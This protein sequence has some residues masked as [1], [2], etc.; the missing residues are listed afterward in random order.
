MQLV[1][2]QDDAALALFHL[3]QHGFQP[4]LKLA[5]V[6]C[7]RHQ[8]AHVQAENRLVLQPLGHVAGHDALGK[9]LG[10]GGLAHARLAD[11]HGVVF[12][13][14]GEDAH[15]VADLGVAADDR[16]QLVGPGGLHQVLAVLFQHVV[17]LLRVL[18]GH[19]LV[20]AHLHQR[21]QKF[22]LVQPPGPKELPHL[23]AGGLKQAQHQMLHRDVLV[24]HLARG[25]FRRREGAVGIGGNINFFRV[26][27]AAGHVGQLCHLGPGRVGHPRA[28]HAH[29]FQ[30]L[31][32][33][34]LAV[35]AER[36]QQVA[37]LQLLVLVFDRQ[38]LGALQR[39]LGF[40][41]QSVQ[42]HCAPNLSLLSVLS[43]LFTN[44]VQRAGSPR[45]VARAGPPAR[46]ARRG[47][48][49]PRAAAPPP[50]R[51]PARR[52]TGAA[53]GRTA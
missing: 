33:Q 21:G 18:A 15:H 16:V 23:A 25:L 53:P 36:P 3:G 24:F 44:P 9:A 7:A 31:G 29:L 22:V 32:D 8:R 19:P 49:P 26:A 51:C 6:L 34:P 47:S 14:A 20:A 41:R 2:E 46:S 12:G 27:A 38:A 17:G 11:E 1:D 35:G 4:L 43:C 40:L 37:L 45:A 48:P 42:I 30:Q 28:V 52:N 50:R 10:D 13:L 39:L 5:P